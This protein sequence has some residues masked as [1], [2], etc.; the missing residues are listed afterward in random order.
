MSRT[1]TC[2]KY[3]TTSGKPVSQKQRYKTGPRAG[4]YFMDNLP[5]KLILF[6]GLCNL[7][8]RSV[9]FVIRHDPAA[10]FHF[11]SLQGDAGI[12]IC[13]KFGFTDQQLDSFILIDEGKAYTQSSAALRVSKYLS[14]GWKLL[15]TFLIVPPFI[16]DAVYRLIARNRYRW[17]GKRDACMIPSPELRQRFLN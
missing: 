5:D 3:F 1:T 8:N 10:R 7:C 13:A 16:R 4:F 2:K 12:A 17:F 15:Y 14:G 6:D 9:Q 11:A